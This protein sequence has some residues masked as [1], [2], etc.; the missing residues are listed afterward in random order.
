MKAGIVILVVLLILAFVLGSAY[1]SRRNQMAIK[2]E[3]VNAAWAQVDV[4]LQRRADLIPNLVQTVKGYAV[5]EQT[6]FGD[7]AAARAALV[8]AK[9]PSDKIAANGQLDSAL[10]RLLVIVENYP[11]LKSNEN[12]MRLQDELAGTEN[13]I[14]VE[15]KRYNDTVQDYNTYIS[16]FPNSVV[17]SFAGFTRNN[18]YFKTDE[19]ARQAP[20]VNFD[21]N[22]P[23]TAPAPTP[24]PAHP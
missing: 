9:T 14:A 1:V 2:R 10:S 22:K 6:V 18:A 21:F 19:G 8:G 17:A 16:L 23:A 7:I 12:F 5:Q 11:Q 3:A 15:R 4:V 13:R 24:A 20:K